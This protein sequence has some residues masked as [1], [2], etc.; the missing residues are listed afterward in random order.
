MKL[1]VLTEGQE[2]PEWLVSGLRAK[3]HSIVRE[4]QSAAV[5]E[6]LVAA[7]VCGHYDLVLVTLGQSDSSGAKLV[8]QIRR[9]NERLPIL[10]MSVR[11]NWD[12]WMRAVRAGANECMVKPSSFDALHDRLDRLWKHAGRV[13]VHRT[14]LVMT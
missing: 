13:S 2:I 4:S 5:A 7:G 3:G 11:R 9:Q 12:V 14:P 8:S 1:L 6:P 10:V